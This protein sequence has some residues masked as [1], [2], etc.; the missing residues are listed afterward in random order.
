M[1]ARGKN[2]KFQVNI[3]KTKKVLNFKKNS[4]LNRDLLRNHLNENKR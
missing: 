2:A 3:L 4:G 1:D